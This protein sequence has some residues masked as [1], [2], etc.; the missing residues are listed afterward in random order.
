LHN[1]EAGMYNELIGKVALVTGG[2]SGIGRATAVR[3]AE[4]GAKVVVADVDVAGGEQTVRMVEDCG[5]TAIFVRADV[6]NEAEVA[7]Q[8]KK[9]N[10]TYGRLDYAVNN[11]GIEGKPAALADLKSADFD[12]IIGI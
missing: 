10:E 6:S 11:T 4:V 7:A 5:S 12:R 3:F 1:Q 2:A 8:V 9:T